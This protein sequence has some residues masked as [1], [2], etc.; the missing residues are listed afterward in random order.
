MLRRKI[1]EMLE[2]HLA[3]L[4]EFA[5]PIAKTEEII[6]A[7]YDQLIIHLF[8]ILAFQDLYNNSKH[9]IDIDQKWGAKIRSAVLKSKPKLKKR[10]L[11]SILVDEAT[12]N[13]MLEI[14]WSSL[15]NYSGLKSYRK[16]EEVFELVR[17]I[18]DKYCDALIQNVVTARIETCITELEI[19]IYG[20]EVYVEECFN[21]K[22]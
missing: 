14:L 3:K 12:S 17:S 18:M 11:K 19:Y 21:S 20:V 10:K 15:S 6:T 7:Q 2:D 13:E 22:I 16:K 8:K 5:N 4:Q 1:Y 9:L